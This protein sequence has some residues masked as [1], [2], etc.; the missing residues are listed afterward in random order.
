MGRCYDKGE[1][2]YKHVG[3]G[4]LPEIAFDPGNPRKWVGKCPA[5]L[6]AQ[7]H[8]KLLEEAIPGRNG[9]RDLSFPKKL[10]AVHNGAVYEAQTSDGGKTYHGYPYRGNLSRTLVKNLRASAQEKKFLDEF[11]LWMKKQIEVHG[12]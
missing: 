10:Y 7:D 11:E 5:T 3:K 8:A 9:D 2:R 12:T 4:D 1:R 6:T